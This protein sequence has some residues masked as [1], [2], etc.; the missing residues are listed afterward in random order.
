M[1]DGGVAGTREPAGFL[2]SRTMAAWPVQ[3]QGTATGEC[4]SQTGGLVGG[5]LRCQ[6]A[7][8]LEAWWSLDLRARLGPP[9]CLIPWPGD[10]R[11]VRDRALRASFWTRWVAVARR[12]SGQVRAGSFRCAVVRGSYAARARPMGVVFDG[13]HRSI[14]SVELVVH[15]P[16]VVLLVNLVHIATVAMLCRGR[17]P[18]WS[19]W[20]RSVVGLDLRRRPRQPAVPVTSC[21]RW[22]TPVGRASALNHGGTS[23][24]VG[25]VAHVVWS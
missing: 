19:V 24:T 5:A 23:V 15:V 22:W 13:T 2:V 1:A 8:C 10:P 25:L 16:Y 6:A 11:R 20:S 14:G 7:P 3:R 9:S 12:A 4:R 17:G 18:G 21:D